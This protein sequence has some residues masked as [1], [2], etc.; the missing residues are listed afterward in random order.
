MMKTRP[1][2]DTFMSEI[3]IYKPFD[4]NNMDS[5]PNRKLPK[6]ISFYL[7]YDDLSILKIVKSLTYSLND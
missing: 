3:N 7:V 1:P 2:P 6:A 5:F 4:T